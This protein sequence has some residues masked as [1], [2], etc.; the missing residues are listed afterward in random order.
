MCR[1]KRPVLMAVIA[2]CL[3]S[4]RL[5][6]S[7]PPDDDYQQALAYEQTPDMPRAEFWYRKAADAGSLDAQLRLAK[8]YREGLKLSQN[9][10]RA[11]HYYRMAAEQGNA[12]AEYKLGTMY[13]GG[14][15]VEQDNQQAVTWFGL[16]A[17][18]GLPQ[19]VQALTIMRHNGHCCTPPTRLS[20]LPM[21]STAAL[22]P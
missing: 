5:G 16:A 11:A 2:T 7:E 21:P 4:T 1:W 3:F 15:G 10:E 13:Y 8:L 20:A 9:D 14:H 18:Q 6:W 12:V 17:R 19:A 22:T